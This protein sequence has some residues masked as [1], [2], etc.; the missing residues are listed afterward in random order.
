MKHK[1][2]LQRWAKRMDFLMTLIRV[3]ACELMGLCGSLISHLMS[4]FHDN[5][6]ANGCYCSL[7]LHDDISKCKGSQWV[8]M[9]FRKSKKKKKK[10]LTA[11]QRW[12]DAFQNENYLTLPIMCFACHVPL[13]LRVSPNSAATPKWHPD[14]RLYFDWGEVTHCGISLRG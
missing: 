9:S 8:L 13:L 11:P 6:N 7:N 14:N 2:S 1:E 12:R 5:T 3:L 10:D 4:T